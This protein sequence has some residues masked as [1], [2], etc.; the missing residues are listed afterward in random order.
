MNTRIGIVTGLALAA[1]TA[2]IASAQTPDSPWGVAIYGGDSVIDSGSLRSPGGTTTLPD[3]GTLNPALIGTPG[4]LKYDKL[5]YDDLFRRRFDTGVELNYSFNDN[6]QTFGRL[7]Y[8]SFEGRTR[9]AAFFTP[10]SGEPGVAL[11]AH[12]ADE[13][14]K[15]LELGSRYFW[16][17]GTPWEPYAGVSLGATRLDAT[18]ADFST[19]DGG[20]DLHNVRFTRPS[21]VFSQSLEAGVEFNPNTNFGVRFSVDADHVG[22]PPSANDPAL[23][24]LGYDAAHDAEAHWSFPVAIAAA[25]HFG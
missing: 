1:G 12:F 24:A 11:R 10:D 6:L 8:E 23:T 18:S 19:A 21:T 15:S 14:S 22:V 17:T 4:T 20:I 2:G 3:L 25:F 13:D 9:R 7:G 16:P 5:N